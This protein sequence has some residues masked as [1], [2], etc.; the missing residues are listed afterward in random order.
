VVKR[1]AIQIFKHF[2]TNIF[3]QSSFLDPSIPW[4]LYLRPI[5]LDFRFIRKTGQISVTYILILP[6]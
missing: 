2:I 6:C 4:R 1:R 3:S 5:D